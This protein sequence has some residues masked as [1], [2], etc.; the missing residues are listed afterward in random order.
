M[1]VALCR[2]ARS[3]SAHAPRGVRV[4]DRYPRVAHGRRQLARRARQPA[5]VRACAR[6]SSGDRA[7]SH[8][9]VG[10][11]Q[12]RRA[13]AAARRSGSRS[14]S[15]SRT[16]RAQGARRCRAAGHSEAQVRL[17]TRGGGRAARASPAPLGRA[18]GGRSRSQNHCASADDAACEQPC[19]AAPV[20]A[21]V[22]GPQHCS[23]DRA[24]SGRTWPVLQ[25]LGKARHGCAAP[26]ALAPSCARARARRGSFG[27]A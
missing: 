17:T 12:R 11:R 14:R 23:R 22:R 3:C 18:L 21:S 9:C 16:V 10:G 4:R 24:P 13:A 20:S 7:S 2:P 27:G 5:R 8:P 6:A 19:A 26:H 15:Q 25:M 1:H